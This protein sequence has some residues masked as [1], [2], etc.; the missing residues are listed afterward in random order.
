[1]N[2]LTNFLYFLQ[3]GCVE[4]KNILKWDQQ[5]SVRKMEKLKLFL[6]SNFF[7][8]PVHVKLTTEIHQLS[9]FGIVSVS[10][11]RSSLELSKILGKWSFLF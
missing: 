5:E 3:H 10:L 4:D 2:A 9:F 7:Y 11:E 1:M 8:W 6:S